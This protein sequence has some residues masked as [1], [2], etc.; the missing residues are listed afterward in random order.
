MNSPE[1]PQLLLGD[2]TK[3]QIDVPDCVINTTVRDLLVESESTC[4]G[5]F[6]HAGFFP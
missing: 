3:S 2:A 1:F 6:G 5:S 4:P